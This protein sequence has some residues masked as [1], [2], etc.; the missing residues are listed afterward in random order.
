MTCRL[1][2]VAVLLIAFADRA[3]ANWWI[4]RASDEKC[5][6]VD[7][8]PTGNDKT[9]TKVAE[10]YQTAEEAEADVKRLCKESKTEDRP[11]RDRGNAK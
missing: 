11:P 4:V 5:L 8:E 3:L 6:V 7:I 1:L 9:V 2:S 10:V